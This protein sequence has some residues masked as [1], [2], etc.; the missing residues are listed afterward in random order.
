MLPLMYE[1]ALASSVKQMNK[2]SN[3]R[4]SNM[5]MVRMPAIM[6]DIKGVTLLQ[7]NRVKSTSVSSS[8]CWDY[9]IEVGSCLI[10]IQKVQPLGGAVL[11]IH[12]ERGNLLTVSIAFGTTQLRFSILNSYRGWI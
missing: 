10:S 6:K 11:N 5:L 8:W 2:P 4:L 9:C 1:M 7:K 12:Q 3:D